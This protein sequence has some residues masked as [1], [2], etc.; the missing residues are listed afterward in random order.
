MTKKWSS[1]RG[2]GCQTKR[3][4]S[5][6]QRRELVRELKRADAEL[7]EATFTNADDMLDWLNSDNQP[8]AGA[9]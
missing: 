3:Q 4:A 1:T 7:P 8:T 9:K 6:N 5:K 2:D